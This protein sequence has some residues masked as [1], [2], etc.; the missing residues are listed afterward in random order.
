MA[1]I[2]T[3]NFLVNIIIYKDVFSQQNIDFGQNIS[4][5]G[6]PIRFWFAYIE[7]HDYP[8]IIKL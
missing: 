8:N 7:N 6:F 4:E 1:K 2:I 5:F 3:V